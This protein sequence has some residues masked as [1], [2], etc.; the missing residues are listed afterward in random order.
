MLAE[1]LVVLPIDPVPCLTVVARESY[2]SIA[3]VANQSRGSCGRAG[4]KM[5]VPYTSYAY[6]C[7]RTGS[8][9]LPAPAVVFIA[10]KEKEDKGDRRSEVN[11]R[12]AVY[13]FREF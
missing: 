7:S 9:N 3:G 11:V 2:S 10:E 13:R 12:P 8:H 4:G 6:F 1:C 5:V